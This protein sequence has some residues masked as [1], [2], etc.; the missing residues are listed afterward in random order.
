[1]LFPSSFHTFLLNICTY[2][3]CRNICSDFATKS[4]VHWPK[5]AAI[6]VP[7]FCK[8]ASIDP[9]TGISRNSTTVPCGLQF[10]VICNAAL[11]VLRRLP[12]HCVG[13]AAAAGTGFMSPQCEQ[14]QERHIH[15]WIILLM[16][17]AN[18]FCAMGGKTTY[19]CIPTCIST[20]KY[21][22]TFRVIEITP[23]CA[24]PVIWYEDALASQPDKA[25]D[26][27][28]DKHEVNKWGWMGKK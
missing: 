15:S 11:Q 26:R 27:K 9:S 1:M 28:I 3:K 4:N 18:E 20:H 10:W 21:A 16:E 24:S 7:T 13:A 17:D 23:Q 14:N 5:C 2:C 22:H 8:I 6:L 12:T 19:E 25:L